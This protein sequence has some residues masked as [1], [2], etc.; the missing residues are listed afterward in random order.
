MP[1]MRNPTVSGNSRQHNAA[2]PNIHQ[3]HNQMYHENGR[4]HRFRGRH[5]P[6][7]MPNWMWERQLSMLM[8]EEMLALETGS[9]DGMSGNDDSTGM[10]GN[11]DSTGMVDTG[12]TG[13]NGQDDTNLEMPSDASDNWQHQ[14]G[15]YPRKKHHK[16]HKHHKSGEDSMRGRGQHE[17]PDNEELSGATQAGQMSGGFNGQSPISNNAMNKSMQPNTYRPPNKMDQGAF[18]SSDEQYSNDVEQAG[19]YDQLQGEQGDYNTNEAQ[20]DASY[21]N[22]SNS[23]YEPDSSQ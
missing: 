11:D 3:G 19:P 15:D 2:R 7:Y 22:L 4:G 16:H 23:S 10:S 1:K 14:L 17:G 8:Q 12:D 18:Q 6:W 13:L 20:V 5:K 21:Y 9:M